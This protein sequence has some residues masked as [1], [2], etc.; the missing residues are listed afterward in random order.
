MFP[1]SDFMRPVAVSAILLATACVPY[2]TKD[3]KR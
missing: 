2:V 3:Y 1:T